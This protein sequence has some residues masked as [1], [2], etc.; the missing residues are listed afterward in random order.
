MYY[1][2]LG[3]VSPYRYL[4]STQIVCAVV[5]RLHSLNFPHP[6]H[7]EQANLQRLLRALEGGGYTS[8]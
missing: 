3:T 4:I 1:E 6:P 8:A 2:L 7:G 5:S